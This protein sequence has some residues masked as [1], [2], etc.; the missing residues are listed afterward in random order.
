MKI[1]NDLCCSCLLMF[2]CNY[3]LQKLRK[4]WTEILLFQYHKSCGCYDSDLP[5]VLPAYIGRTQINMLYNTK[6]SQQIKHIDQQELYKAMNLLG[7]LLQ[8]SLDWKYSSRPMP[9]S[10]PMECSPQMIATSLLRRFR[11]SSC[12]L[13][14]PCFTRTVHLMW[15]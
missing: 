10:I 2:F 6:S 8:E 3:E 5:I 4:Q 14:L 13:K 7:L 12:S 1:A 9:A 11:G 15:E